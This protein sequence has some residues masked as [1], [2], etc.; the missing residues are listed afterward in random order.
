MESAARLLAPYER[1]LDVKIT[2][3]DNSRGEGV[4]ISYRCAT[5]MQKREFSSPVYVS[6]RGDAKTLDAAGRIAAE[7]ILNKHAE[8][9]EL[10][11]P[12]AKRTWLETAGI[13][14]EET[15]TAKAARA[16]AAET[17]SADLERLQKFDRN[18]AKV[19]FLPS[20]V[21]LISRLQL[22]QVNAG[23]LEIDRASTA[24]FDD[25]ELTR[26]APFKSNKNKVQLSPWDSSAPPM[27]EGTARTRIWRAL[28]HPA[29][30]LIRFVRFWTQALIV[31]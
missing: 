5:C 11:H 24:N 9:L 21:A 18:D 2:T 22:V 15:K 14:L 3:L 12:P 16:T 28:H 4:R 23:A 13:E 27:A 19:R 8:C 30:G 31:R 26:S 1:H 25:P 20:I 6:A 7:R 10:Q 17:E 29:N